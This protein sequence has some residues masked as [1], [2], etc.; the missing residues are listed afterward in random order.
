MGSWPLALLLAL[1]GTLASPATAQWPSRPKKKDAT[2]TPASKPAEGQPSTTAPE[3]QPDRRETTTTAESNAGGWS[4]VLESMTGT[5]AME[6]A[7]HRQAVL[8]SELGRSDVR[9]RPTARGYAL[10][11]GSYSKPDSPDAREALAHL[12]AT[13]VDGRTPFSQAFF[14]PPKERIDP[15]SIPELNLLAAR[16]VFGPDKEYTLQIAFYQS[17]KPD[18]AKRAAEN[19]ALQLRREGEL[20]FYYHG[21]T[22]S[23]VTVGLFE[24]SDFDQG[25]RPKNA[26][27]LSLQERYPLNLH[28]GEYPVITKQPGT[29]DVKQPSQLVKIP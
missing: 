13:T 14:V 21:P 19:A 8:A 23:L 12:R 5:N 10:V 25:L 22:M 29:P 2:K 9:L 27:I 4:I 20:A 6:A 17:G 15:G 1:S 28:N 16:Q 26:S 11:L 3:K 24:D 7:Q 18:D